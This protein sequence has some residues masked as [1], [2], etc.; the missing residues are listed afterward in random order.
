M[1]KVLVTGGDGSLGRVLVDRLVGRGD[2]VVSLDTRPG[3]ARADVEYATVDLRDRSA[4]EDACRGVDVVF[5]T[6]ALVD[7]R[8]ARRELIESVNVGGTDNLLRAAVAARVGRFV[9]VSTATVVYSGADIEGGDESLPYAARPQSHYAATKAVAEQHVLA[10]DD[11]GGLR[12]C[13]LRPEGIYG[14]GDQRTVPAI[15]EAYR[16]GVNPFHV[17][18]ATKLTDHVYIDS[19]VDAL[20][21]ADERLGVGE[22]VAGQAYFVTDGTPCSFVDFVRWTCEA[23]GLRAPRLGVPQPVMAVAAMMAEALPEPLRRFVPSGV[24]ETSRFT[25]GYMHHHHWFRI[26]KAREQLGYEPRVSTRQGI[27]ATVESLRE[28]QSRN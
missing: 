19:L 6:A 8:A 24:A 14:P 26:D 10:A 18:D 12:T 7:T 4:V 17:G 21:A 23:A 15:L 25:V 27:A 2:E 22:P 9:H 3:P 28:P 1:T 5:H 13:A 16:L 11:P 20:L